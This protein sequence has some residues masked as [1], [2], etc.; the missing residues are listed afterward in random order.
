MKIHLVLKT[1][2]N[3]VRGLTP[4]VQMLGIFIEIYFFFRNDQGN[5][6]GGATDSTRRVQ[7]Q[8]FAEFR[9]YFSKIS[10]NLDKSSLRR[11]I[12]SRPTI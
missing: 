10:A 8:T 4:D 6:C 1:V 11:V 12:F 3:I 5:V 9:Q 2:T 7:T